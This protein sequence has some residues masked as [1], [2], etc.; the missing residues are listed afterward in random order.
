MTRQFH[1]SDILSVTT[2]RLVSTRHMDGI[3]DILNYMT[4]EQ[5]FTHQLPRAVTVC[6]PVLLDQHPQLKSASD[7]EQ[8]QWESWLAEQIKRFGETLEVKPLQPGQ[9]ETKH[10]LTELTDM[11]G[12]EK[13]KD[14]IVIVV[15]SEK[16][17]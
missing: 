3:Y 8:E 16:D 17:D 11:V 12:P 6:K 1:L 14:A 13:A 10:P 9:Y 4:G 7:F 2:G 15:P 5:L